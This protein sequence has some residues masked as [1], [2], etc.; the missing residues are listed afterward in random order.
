MSRL[1]GMTFGVGTFAV[2]APGV[3]VRVIEIRLA[4]RHHVRR[5]AAARNVQTTDKSY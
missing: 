5:R 1:P 2:L 3:H 4:V